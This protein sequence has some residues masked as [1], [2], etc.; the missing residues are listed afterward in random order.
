[1]LP[2]ALCRVASAV[3]GSPQVEEPVRSWGA[4]A[5]LGVS[6]MSNWRSFPHEQVAW[7]P[8]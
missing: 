1:M 3:L 6:P 8:P 2:K 4:S 5:V 7:F